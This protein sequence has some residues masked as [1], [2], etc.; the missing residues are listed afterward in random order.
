MVWVFW[1]AF[2]FLAYT[3]AG[4]PLLLYLLS[5]VRSRPHHRSAV[6]PTVSFITT[7]H[8]EAARLPEKIKNSLDVHYPEDRRE[9]IVASDGSQDTTNEI[10]RSFASQGVKLVAIAEKHGKHYA[11][12]MAR[13]AS[14]GEILVFTD[15]AVHVEPDILEKI[16]CNFADP[17]VGCVSSEDYIQNTGNLA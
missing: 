11:Q 1:L 7:A 16:V 2:V 13:D 3:F 8:N 10:V 4:Y 14:R 9:M 5:C 15:V 6:W 17:S 12:M